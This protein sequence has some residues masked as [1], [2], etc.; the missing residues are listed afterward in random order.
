M[1]ADVTDHGLSENKFQ[2]YEKA[3]EGLEEM[4]A[5]VDREYRYMLANR[6][7][8]DMRNMTRQEVVG[9]LAHEVLNQGVFEAGVKEKL[10]QCFRGQ[11]VRFE[12]KYTY[13]E[14]GERDI[15]VSYFPIEGING[16]DRV[17]CIVHDITERKLAEA[18]QRESEERFRL[19][20][21]NAPVMIWMSGVD[22]QPAY[23]NQSWLDFT[24]RSLEDELRT[25]LTAITHPDDSEECREVYNTAFE[26][27][28]PFRKECRLRRHDG[29]YRWVL[30]TG[31]PRFLADGSFAG[32]IGS[33]V[34]I[35]DQKLA[36]EALS[37]VNRRLIEAHE[38][39]RARI[40]RE[41]HDDINQRLALLAMELYG[42][43]QVLPVSTDE[44]TQQIEAAAT[45]VVDLGKDIQAMSHRLHSPKLEYLGL[46]AAASSLCREFSD[47][48]QAE[49][50]FH[51]E[52]VPKDL[53]N[54]VSLCLYRVLQEALQ[55]AVKHSGS[56]KFQV[57]LKGGSNE[58]ELTVCDSGIGFPPEEAINGRGLGLTSMKERLSAVGGLLFIDSKLQSGAKI[59]ARVPLSSRIKPTRAGD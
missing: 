21:N 52:N 48:Q 24:G 55:N 25:G 46:A 34:D 39:E 13:P 49:V 27:R 1:V 58:I 33:C 11:I 57:S 44:L 38:G 53:S 22:K 28:R 32:Y 36:H 35:T 2:E 19:M 50:D 3:V 29:E 16:I 14:I 6:K 8:L 5:V 59:R 31:V 43:K 51:S 18:R 54:D 45:Q 37:K 56:R 17:A 4:I 40:A 47:R 10:D 30:D 42:L 26:L 20:A 9:R 41:L 15:L 12:M 23:F 7:F